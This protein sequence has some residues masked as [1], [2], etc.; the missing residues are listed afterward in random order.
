MN[1]VILIGRLA[2]EPEVRYL[3]E[4]NPLCIARYTLAVNRRGKDEEADFIRCV[5][6]GKDAEFAERY[7]MKG[8]KL[9]VCGRIQTGS[10]INREGR[11]IY[12]TDVIIESQE[13]AES[14]KAAGQT[15]PMP[16]N[17]DGFMEIPDG[18]EDEGLPFA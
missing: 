11:R 1:K 8:I 7:L 9:A 10:Y 6:F 16:E 4:E 15:E 5:A 13:F 3:G 14:K 17:E 2:R 12:T 18:V